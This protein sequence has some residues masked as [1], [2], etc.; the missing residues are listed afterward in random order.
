MKNIL[1]VLFHPNTWIRN[2]RTCKILDKWYIEKMENGE[3]FK[4]RTEC[5]ANFG[6]KYIWIANYPYASF[7][8]MGTSESLPKRKTVYELHNLLMK[9]ILEDTK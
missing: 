8:I 2:Y 7:S 4:V 3:K 6:G 1:W 9:S 5:G